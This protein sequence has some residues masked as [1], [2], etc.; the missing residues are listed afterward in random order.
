MDLAQ[1]IVNAAAQQLKESS[2]AETCAISWDRYK[3]SIWFLHHIHT[4]CKQTAML[5]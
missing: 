4:A 5:A 3:C 1:M 2:M